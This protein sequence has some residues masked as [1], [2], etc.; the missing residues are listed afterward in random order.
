MSLQTPSKEL[1]YCK[2]FV[3]VMF[4]SKN[5]KI[6]YVTGLSGN[7][8]IED[9]STKLHW[10]GQNFSVLEICNDCGRISNW[11]SI[12]AKEDVTKIKIEDQIRYDTEIE[13]EGTTDEEI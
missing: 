13:S 1:N 8:I 12:K 3:Y 4:K 11:N 5:H 6:D 10:M 9:C 7:I 2:S